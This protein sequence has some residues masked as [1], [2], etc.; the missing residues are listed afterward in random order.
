MNVGNNNQ[1]IYVLLTHMLGSYAPRDVRGSPCDNFW[2]MIFCLKNKVHDD[3]ENKV[4]DSF[5]LDINLYMT[6]KQH[7]TNITFHNI[8]YS[9]TY[10]P[11][12][13][14]QLNQTFFF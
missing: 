9:P 7:K 3:K 2:P 10:I 13:H 5:M 11:T 8:F 12:Q 4:Q 6:N 1:I 14:T